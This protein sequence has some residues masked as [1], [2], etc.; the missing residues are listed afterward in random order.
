MRNK[1]LY[2]KK[3]KEYQA[4]VFQ[5]KRETDG[6]YYGERHICGNRF[7]GKV[8]GIPQDRM[9]EAAYS[10]VSN[11]PTLKTKNG[12]GRVRLSSA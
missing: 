12:Q 10:F 9:I 11:S 3:R 4:K 6:E 5:R 2:N 7:L 1:I 8:I